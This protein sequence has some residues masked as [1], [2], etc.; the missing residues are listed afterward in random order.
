MPFIQGSNEEVTTD[1]I[2]RGIGGWVADSPGL[3]AAVELDGEDDGVLA[4]KP[5][6]PDRN[7]RDAPRTGSYTYIT[8]RLIILISSVATAI[9]F[10]YRTVPTR[11]PLAL[12]HAAR[13][14]KV[15]TK[16]LA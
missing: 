13:D 1:D 2:L 5:P 8:R 6:H 9:I 10:L 11:T 12:K 3:T 14:I 16:V 4:D 7:V 15:R